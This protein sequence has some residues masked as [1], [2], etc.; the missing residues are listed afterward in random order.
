MRAW[1]KKLIIALL[2]G[3]FLGFV[4]NMIP[5]HGTTP[6]LVVLFHIVLFPLAILFISRSLRRYGQSIAVVVVAIFGWTAVKLAAEAVTNPDT[7]PIAWEVWGFG[8]FIGL[9][10]NVVLVGLA[11]L[12]RRWLFP[13][14]PSGHCQTCG[15]NLT[16]LPEPRCPECGQPFEEVTI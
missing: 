14:Y 11:T 1:H 3:V 15:Y 10:V 4:H 8:G 2:V 12:L 5:E 7:V 9:V 13:I 16:G 6:L